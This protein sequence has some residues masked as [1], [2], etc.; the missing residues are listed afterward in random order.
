VL[1]LFGHLAPSGV[2]RRSRDGL[3]EIELELPE[4]GELA[5]SPLARALREAARGVVTMNP[6]SLLADAI[7]R[8]WDNRPGR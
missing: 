6:W 1:D 7:R 8:S 3:V 4:R 5:G 2:T